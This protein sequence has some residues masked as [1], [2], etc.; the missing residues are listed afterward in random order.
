MQFR[1]FLSLEIV[2]VNRNPFFYPY[3]TEDFTLGVE[4]LAK[5][6]ELNTFQDERNVN[7]RTS[8]PN[9]I[10]VLSK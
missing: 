2:R 7:G 8:T 4:D 1:I 3:A 9:D 5:D 10:N 6:I